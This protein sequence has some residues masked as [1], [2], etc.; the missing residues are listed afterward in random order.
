MHL[1]AHLLELETSLT[2]PE[3]RRSRPQLES[4]LGAEFFEFTTSGRHLTREEI[5]Q[6]LLTE[7]PAAWLITEFAVHPLSEVLVLATFRATRS[8]PAETAHSLRSSVWQFA[9]A[10]WQLRFHQGTRALQ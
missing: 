6:A 4:L 2:S 5:I 9:G 3:T 1:H 10:R 8:T 7:S